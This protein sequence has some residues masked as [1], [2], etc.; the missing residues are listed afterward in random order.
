VKGGWR[1]TGFQLAATTCAALL[2]VSANAAPP[3]PGGLAPRAPQVMLYFTHNLGGGAGSVFGK[4]TFGLRIQQIRQA[5]NSGDPEA[6]NDPMSHRELIDWQLQ[7]RSS[8]RVS[9]GHRLTYD[10]TNRTFGR[11]SERRPIMAFGGTHLRNAVSGGGGGAAAAI[12]NV[13]M[14]AAGMHNGALGNGSL[15]DSFNRPDARMAAFPGSAFREQAVRDSG[16]LHEIAA[17]AVAALNPA[18]FTAQARPAPRAGVA[19]LRASTGQLR[20]NN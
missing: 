1:S 9:L 12:G 5:G 20:A 4:P 2:G 13:A 6:L 7:G 16:S 14:S 11:P 18:R 15:R 3:S 10:L 17:A 19:A 8:L